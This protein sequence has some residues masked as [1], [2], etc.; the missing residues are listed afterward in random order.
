[1]RRKLYIETTVVSYLVAR[2]SKSKV[3]AGHQESTLVFWR[4]LNE[5]DGYFS[6][7]VWREASRGDEAQAKARLEILS[8]L[9]MLEADIEAK[10]LAAKLLK[11]LAI[12]SEYPDDA[13][14]IAIATVNGMDFIVTWNFKHIN[15]PV[16]RAKIRAV[17]ENAGYVAP[18]IC[19]PEEVVEGEQ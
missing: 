2:P 17:V 1:M 3:V 10:R 13:L 6:D 15:N 14:H 4:R 9:E 19:S 5:F 7:L 16:M 12:P 18:E 11:G 8:S